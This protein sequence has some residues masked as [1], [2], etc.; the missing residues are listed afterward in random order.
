MCMG[1]ENNMSMYS[2]GLLELIDNLVHELISILVHNFHLSV[3]AV[4][5]MSQTH[6]CI[7]LC[8][9]EL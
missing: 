4:T 2:A 1:L 9:A 8:I 5:P 7:M 6:T 3:V